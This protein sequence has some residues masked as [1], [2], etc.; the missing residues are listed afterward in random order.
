MGSPSAYAAIFSNRARREFI[1]S[2]NWYEDRQRGL[3]DRFLKEVA[4]RV[5]M[6][7]RA[8]GKFPT[9]FKSYK[10]TPVPVFPFLII[11]RI[12]EKKRL[13]RIVSLFHTARNPRKKY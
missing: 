8:P 10:E 2:W 11:Y 3:G 6:I 13:I 12:N 5:E 1:Q 9:R 7:E 4:D